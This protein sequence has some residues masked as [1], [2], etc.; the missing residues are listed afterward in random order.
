MKFRG[1]AVQHGTSDAVDYA[2]YLRR[3]HANHPGHPLIRYNI[4]RYYYVTVLIGRINCLLRSSVRLLYLTK[5]TVSFAL[6]G[7]IGVE[8]TSILRTVCMVCMR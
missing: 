3:R 5:I 7:M 1:G 4:F 2:L 8:R 6:A